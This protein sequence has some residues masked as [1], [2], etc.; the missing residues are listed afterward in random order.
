MF[1]KEFFVSWVDTDWK[2]KWL[3]V[4]GY[5]FVGEVDFGRSDVDVILGVGSTDGIGFTDVLVV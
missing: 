2:G 3:G 4:G 1:W 5:E